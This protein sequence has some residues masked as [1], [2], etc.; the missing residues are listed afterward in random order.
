[1]S[2]ILREKYL[3]EIRGFY[4]SDLVKIITGVRRC[5]KSV[6]M[7]QIAA[8]LREKTD[9]ILCLDFDDRHATAFIT[10]WEDIV[11]YVQEKRGEGLCY[12]LLDEVQEIDGWEQACRSLRRENCSVFITGSDSRLLSGEFTKALSGRYVAFRVRP[13]VYRE[14]AEYAAQLGRDFSVMDYL[15][16]GGFPK[17]L[18]FATEQEQ[19]RY[20]S[21]LDDTIVANDIINR[22][23]I[24]KRSEFRRVAG[25]ILISNA[26][27]YSAKSIADHMTGNGINVTPNTVH[28]WIEYLKEAYVVDELP[29]Y[30]KKA[31]RELEQS[32]KLYDCDVALNSVRCRDNRYDITHNLENA[33]FNELLYLGY[34]VSVYDNNGREIDFLA[35]KGGRRC[36]IQVAWTVAEEKTWEREFSAFRGIDSLDRR[37]L[38][39]NDDLDYS[40][41]TV[42]HV[43][44]KDFLVS[45][46]P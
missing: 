16:W 4:D 12:V 29:R 35:E 45:G 8:E 20:I 43:R 46:L 14:L 15:V 24:R 25:F 5:G 18:E 1:M 7:E 21:D 38:I 11:R 9:N 33:V 37:V 6:V 36:Y 2:V 39:S 44:L 22:Y 10:G 13:F 40:T 23:G 32:R 34:T 17:R 28:K 30:S 31:K 19:R 26:R 42:E 41:G 3:R 27:N